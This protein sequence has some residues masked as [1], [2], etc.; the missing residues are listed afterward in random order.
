MPRVLSRARPPGRP[1]LGALPRPG[2]S[3]NPSALQKSLRSLGTAARSWWPASRG[4]PT[5]AP[6]P[7]PGSHV[8]L[9]APVALQLLGLGP[10]LSGPTLPALHPILVT[11]PPPARPPSA[12]PCWG[13]RRGLH[14]LPQTLSPALRRTP[15]W[16]SRALWHPPQSSKPSSS[17]KALSPWR[18]PVCVSPSH[19]HVPPPPKQT[20]VTPL[21]PVHSAQ[22]PP[23]GPTRTLGAGLWPLRQ[24]QDPGRWPPAPPTTPG[25]WVLASSSSD[26]PLEPGQGPVGHGPPGAV[27]AVRPGSPTPAHCTLCFPSAWEPSQGLQNSVLPVSLRISRPDLCP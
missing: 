27:C 12:Q 6:A 9:P 22:G 25:S 17:Y 24:P 26:T 8:S 18:F 14:R 1:P 23:Q 2:R 11:F 16:V 15:P 21:A 13:A 4:A 7:P 20:V 3:A 5:S 19:P 10:R